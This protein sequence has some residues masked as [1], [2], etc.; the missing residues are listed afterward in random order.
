MTTNLYRYLEVENNI[1][2]EN[3]EE[4]YKRLLKCETDIN[5]VNKIH[6]AYNILLDYGIKYYIN[7]KYLPYLNLKKI[8][9]NYKKINKVSSC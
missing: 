6:E 4:Q 1:D 9:K 3:L 5:K 8:K 7:T 2:N